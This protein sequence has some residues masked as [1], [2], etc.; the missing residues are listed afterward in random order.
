MRKQ[1]RISDTLSLVS[2]ISDTFSPKIFRDYLEE[3]EQLKLG[4][5]GRKL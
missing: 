2:G 3:E 5:P 4:K 1:R